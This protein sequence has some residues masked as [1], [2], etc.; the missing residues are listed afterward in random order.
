M[1]RPDSEYCGDTALILT[2]LTR[3]SEVGNVRT[4]ARDE[5]LFET[6]DLKTNV[7]RVEA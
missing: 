2:A 1:F 3:Q 6:G 7:Y 5:L 4:L